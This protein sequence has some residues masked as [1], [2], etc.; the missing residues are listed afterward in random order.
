MGTTILTSL[1]EAELKELLKQTVREVLNEER[2]SKDNQ[3]K[4]NWSEILCVKEAS[5]F[6]KLK[7]N[8]LYEKTSRKLIPHFKKGNKLYFHLAE[9]QDWIKHG[10]VKTFQ[11]IENDAI[12]YNLNR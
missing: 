3:S 11:E 10:K 7:I 2:D 8:T 1:T 6:L 12:N 4:E 9:L 5:R